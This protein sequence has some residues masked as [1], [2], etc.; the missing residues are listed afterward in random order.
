MEF[1]V[2]PSSNAKSSAAPLIM[3][4]LGVRTLYYV[5]CCAVVCAYVIV[6]SYVIIIIIGYWKF[7]Y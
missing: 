5:Y 3:P 2:P 4:S 7:R 6:L 1:V